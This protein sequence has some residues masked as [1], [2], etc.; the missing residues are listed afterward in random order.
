ML[1]GMQHRARAGPALQKLVCSLKE[2]SANKFTTEPQPP[3]A[4][5]H[6]FKGKLF[7]ST[8]IFANALKSGDKHARALCCQSLFV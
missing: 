2:I 7:S 8:I 1:D 6:M 5:Y 4:V 3:P